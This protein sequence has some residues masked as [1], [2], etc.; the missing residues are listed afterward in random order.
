MSA[1]GWRLPAKKSVF[2]RV[3]RWRDLCVSFQCRN[4]TRKRL[5]RKGIEAM[6]SNS[7]AGGAVQTLSAVP[8]ERVS[9]HTTVK[10]VKAHLLEPKVE[11]ARV[12]EPAR[13]I[14]VQVYNS[15]GEV[16]PS[17]ASPETDMTA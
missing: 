5:D 10:T 9:E 2:L 11:D 17:P 15:H 8:P 14:P 13:Q 16:I 6:T 7:V 3:R 4:Q 1:H 12:N